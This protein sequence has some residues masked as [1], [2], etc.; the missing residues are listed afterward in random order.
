MDATLDITNPYLVYAQVCN[1]LMKRVHC[2]TLQCIYAASF[3]YVVGSRVGAMQ[4]RGLFFM[5]CCVV[6]LRFDQT[7]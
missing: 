3:A 6:R 1:S 5:L 4:D 2:K 7:I